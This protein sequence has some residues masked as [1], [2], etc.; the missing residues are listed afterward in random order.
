VGCDSVGPG[1]RRLSWSGTVR[2]GTHAAS[3]VQRRTLQVAPHNYLY[4]TQPLV[5]I[6]GQLPPHGIQTVTMDC[7]AWLALTRTGATRTKPCPR[8]HSC[9][10]SPGALRRRLCVLVLR[11]TSFRRC[12]CVRYAAASLLLLPS[13]CCFP[14]FPPFSGPRAPSSGAQS[15]RQELHQPSLRLSAPGHPGASGMC[16]C[17]RVCACVCECASVR[18]CVCACVRVCV[19]ACVRVCVC[20][21][22]CRMCVTDIT[23]FLSS[24][25]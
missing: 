12:A 25:G 14:L 9:N 3:C 15:R 6:Q 16:A 13:A 1:C 22:V 4:S 10:R 18:V 24:P 11:I 7:V 19:C 8:E 20:V 21:R 17:V 5:P 23:T 2:H